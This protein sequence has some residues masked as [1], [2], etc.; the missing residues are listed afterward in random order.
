MAPP[1][2]PRR[3]H[4]EAQSYYGKQRKYTLVYFDG[5]ILQ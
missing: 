3:A 5:N 2:W 4:R 1:R